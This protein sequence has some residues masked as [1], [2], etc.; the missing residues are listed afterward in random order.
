MGTVRLYLPEGSVVA[1]ASTAPPAALAVAV[2][3][4]PGRVPALRESVTVP[5]IV[6][7]VGPE[8][9]PGPAVPAE[10]APPEPQPQNISDIAMAIT[11]GWMPFL[12]IAPSSGPIV[13]SIH[14]RGHCNQ[15]GP[16]PSMHFP[17]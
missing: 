16:D 5:E 8:A 13:Y 11:A 3:S 9:P 1:V 6:P 15:R 14:S 4:T 2:T 12:P 10:P 7:V 17:G